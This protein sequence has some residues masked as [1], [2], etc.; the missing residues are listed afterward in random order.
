VGEV[1]IYTTPPAAILAPRSWA[2]TTLDAG[3]LEH[4]LDGRL[5]VAIAS[6]HDLREGVE[7]LVALLRG[8]GVARCEWWGPDDHGRAF[9]LQLADG[10]PRGAR[11]AVPLG[12]A[13]ALVLV[14]GHATAELIAPV[15]NAVPLLR[16]RW[17]E[18][19][20]GAH[21]TRLA[22]ENAALDD[23]A[24]LVAHDLKSVLLSALR[25]RDPSPAVEDALE[26]VDSILDV[27][28]AES[29]TVA[30]ARV[31]HCLKDA[32]HDLGRIDAAVAADVAPT[33]PV[34][35]A[36]LR[37]L[38]RNLLR[39]A[40]AAGSREIHV[41]TEED[42]GIWTLAVDDDGVGLG[43]SAGY[44]SGSGLGLGLCRRLVSRLGGAL[45][46]TPRPGGGTRAALVFAEAGA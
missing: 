9:R 1:L 19:Q 39:N 32:L 14:G 5:L 8:R 35:S 26:L 30:P 13:G 18:E 4:T 37:L 42:D 33:L 20:L 16:R 28:R 45:E 25:Q 10:E 3:R 29:A 11:T 38:L 36:A 46:L 31:A 15:T 44:A 27:A 41:T 34:P 12:P 24:M 22:R 43:A 6:A 17:A 2:T 23:F 7:R 40:V 21:V